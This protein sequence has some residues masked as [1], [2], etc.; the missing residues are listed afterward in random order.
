LPINRY[1]TFYVEDFRRNNIRIVE[2]KKD[3]VEEEI[4]ELNSRT[5]L[6]N[7]VPAEE[8]KIEKFEEKPPSIILQTMPK[9]KGARW[10]WYK[11]DLTKKF[12][13]FYVEKYFSKN[14]MSFVQFRR[15]HHSKILFQSFCMLRSW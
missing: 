15:V 10:S 9:V 2:D 12:I 8:K 5:K 4:D 13:E 11:I 7:L 3:E 1:N 6:E 14:S